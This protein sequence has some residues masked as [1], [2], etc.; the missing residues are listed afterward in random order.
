MKVLV[1]GA[2]GFV[3][4]FLCDLLTRSNHYVIGAQRNIADSIKGGWHTVSVGDIGEDTQWDHV[5]N[6]V[7]TVVHLAARVHV[8]Q[9]ITKDPLKLYRQVN[10]RGTEK[11]ARAAATS[12]VKRFVFLS[13]VKVNGEAT[14]AHPFS[15]QSAENPKSPYG[16]SKWE[17]EQTLRQIAAETEM[18]VVILRPPLIYGPGVKANFLRLLSWV[19]RGIPLPLASVNNRRSMIYIGNLASA[20]SVCIDHP[21]AAGKTYLVSDKE[22]VSTAEL[23]RAIAEAKRKSARLWPC[24]VPILRILFG[25]AGKSAET[26]RLL[27]SLEIDHSKICLELDWQPPYTL[28]QGLLRTVN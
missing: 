21:A 7:D 24:P 15:E 18:E 14:E 23:I 5:L 3:G 25:M 8:M 26:G 27:D 19:E 9:E 2:N 12:G 28:Q 13:S 1:T 10:V 11:L 6:N 20:L 17:A 22:V 4:S 16:I